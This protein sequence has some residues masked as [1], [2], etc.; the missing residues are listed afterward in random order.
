LIMEAFLGYTLVWSQMSFWAGTVITS[1]LS[2]IPVF[3]RTLV[4]WIW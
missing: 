2:V 3:G 4:F 1:L